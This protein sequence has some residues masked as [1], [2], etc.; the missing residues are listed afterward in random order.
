MVAGWKGMGSDRLGMVGGLAESHRARSLSPHNKHLP[1]GGVFDVIDGFH[2]EM[3]CNGCREKDQKSSA[4]KLRDWAK[5]NPEEA[6]ADGELLPPP[7][8]ISKAPLCVY[9]GTC[10][11]AIW[12]W[13]EEL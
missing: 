10:V 5:V 8:C 7:R 1:I 3:T 11:D 9:E 6:N 13:A 4:E 2:C 12:R